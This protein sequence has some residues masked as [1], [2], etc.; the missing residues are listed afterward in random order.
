MFRLIA[1]IT[2]FLFFVWLIPMGIYIKASQE[3]T[4][5][6]GQRAICLCSHQQAK[7]KGNPAEG[8][9]FKNGSA[10][11]K[12]SNASGGGAGHYFLAAHLPIKNSLSSS[13]FE[14]RMVLAYRNPFL[15]SIEHIPK[16]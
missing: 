3:K 4:A 10:N 9:N 12:E 7:V 14:S 5:C 1:T 15:K 6:G 13:L 8:Y 16:V 11:N 2:A